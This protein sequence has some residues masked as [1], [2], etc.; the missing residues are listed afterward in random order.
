MLYVWLTVSYGAENGLEY[1]SIACHPQDL[2]QNK[3]AFAL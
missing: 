1:F 2:Y 3:T